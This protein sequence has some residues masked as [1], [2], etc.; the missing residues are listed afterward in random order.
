M[1]EQW[2]YSI[3]SWNRRFESEE[4][5]HEKLNGCGE[6]GWEV[7]GFASTNEDFVCILKRKKQK[8]E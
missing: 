8:V 3:I 1:A 2:E 5:L 6:G 4:K 7:V